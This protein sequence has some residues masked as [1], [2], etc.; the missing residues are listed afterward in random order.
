[1]HNFI[2]NIAGKVHKIILYFTHPAY[3]GA[4]TLPPTLGALLPK[5]ADEKPIACILG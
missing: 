2:F 3:P 1:M 4:E 5:A